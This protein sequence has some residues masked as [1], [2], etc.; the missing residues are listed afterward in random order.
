M[1]IADLAVAHPM[2]DRTGESLLS[3]S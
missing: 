1:S 3:E 2:I